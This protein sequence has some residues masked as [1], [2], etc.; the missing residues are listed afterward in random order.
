MFASGPQSCNPISFDVLYIT[1]QSFGNTNYLPDD[2]LGP[3]EPT[4]N[5]RAMPMR[6]IAVTAQILI[7]ITLLWLGLHGLLHLFASASLRCMAQESVAT[8]FL[9]RY[10]AHLFGLEL[11]G[12]LLLLLGRGKVLT[13]ILV[14]PIALNIVFFHLFMGRQ[15]RLGDSA[16]SWNFF[17]QPLGRKHHCRSSR[18]S[19]S[20][21]RSVSRGKP[22]ASQPAR[23]KPDRRTFRQI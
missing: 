10:I 8:I 2:P 17:Q 4:F 18:S 19:S 22:P 12:S 1:V 11:L 9:S 5:A 13:L 3:R 20:I 23:L 16:D 14:G 15:H 21:L 6:V 7:G